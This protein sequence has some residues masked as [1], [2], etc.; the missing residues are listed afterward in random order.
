VTFD[1]TNTVPDSAGG[2]RF[3]QEFGGVVYAKQVLSEATSFIWTTFD[4]DDPEDRPGY[5][6]VILTVVDNI[7]P[8]AQTIGNTIQ[9]RAQYVAGFNGDVKEEV[10]PAGGRT[11]DF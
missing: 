4:E 8:V 11:I 10:T 3:D 1:A 7:S 6:S 9:L 5:D 2:Q